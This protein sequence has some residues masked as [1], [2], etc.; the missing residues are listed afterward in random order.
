MTFNIFAAKRV[1]CL[2]QYNRIDDFIA[3][4]LRGDNRPIFRQF[5]VDELHIPAVFKRFDPLF[6]LHFRFESIQE[7]GAKI[8]T[9]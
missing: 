1:S 5:L 2:G 3:G 9:Q 6:V 4:N 7:A 8:V